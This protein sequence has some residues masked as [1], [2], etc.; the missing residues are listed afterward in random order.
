MERLSVFD[1]M[2][3]GVGPSSSHT[4]GPW[5]AALGFLAELEENGRFDH[6]TALTIDLYGSLAKTG[7][8]HG[9]DLALLMGLRGEDPVTCDTTRLAGYVADCRATGRVALL[10]RRVIPF[11]MDADIRFH[12]DESLDFHPNGMTF[13]AVFDDGAP[14][15]ATCYSIGGG[16]VTREGQEERPS[17]VT[18]PYPADRAAEVLAH[19]RRDDLALWQMVW[20]NEQAWRTPDEIRAGLLALWETMLDAIYRG[21]HTGGTLPGGLDVARRAAAM[22]R[23]LMG[24]GVTV[25]PPGP[26]AAP[27]ATNGWRRCAHAAM[28]SR[29]WSSGSAASP[30]P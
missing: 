12:R 30:W 23:R 5:R 13:T 9:T 1:M 24:D 17:P 15:A 14:Y 25:R 22:H 8:G 29:A 19:C 18:L 28:T 4:L 21:C 20:A 7:R 3:I 10:G 16:F 6:I 27:S 26:A 2:K 11:D